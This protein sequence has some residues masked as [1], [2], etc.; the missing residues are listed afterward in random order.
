MLDHAPSTVPAARSAAARRR[1]RAAGVGECC[2][3]CRRSPG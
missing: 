1:R 3:W 2:G